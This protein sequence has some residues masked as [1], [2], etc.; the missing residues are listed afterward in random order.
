MFNVQFDKNNIDFSFF[1]QE[2]DTIVSA[3]YFVVTPTG[4]GFVDATQ[5]LFKST[6]L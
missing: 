2:K 1:K 6:N 3:V 4:M 5:L